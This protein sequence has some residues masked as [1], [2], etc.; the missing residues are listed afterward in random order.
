MLGLVVREGEVGGVEVKGWGRGCE[1]WGGDERG[2]GAERVE[3]GMGR[4]S[5][6]NSIGL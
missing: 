4:E 2:G 3:E 6:M 5:R 1:V